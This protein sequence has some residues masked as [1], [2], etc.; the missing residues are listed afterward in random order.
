M[1]TV[2]RWPS[3]MLDLEQPRI[4]RPESGTFVNTFA[5]NYW[6]GLYW[7]FSSR[8]QLAFR[9]NKK[10]LKGITSGLGLRLIQIGSAKARANPFG[11]EHGW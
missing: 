3:L 2:E 11:P 5:E 10:C 1:R 9:A 7:N 8:Y 6:R 4:G